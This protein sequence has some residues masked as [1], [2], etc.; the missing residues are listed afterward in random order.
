MLQAKEARYIPPSSE[1]HSGGWLL[2]STI[3]EELTANPND[4][5]LEMISPGQYFLRTPEID[6][7]HITRLRNW[8]I[9]TPTWKLLYELYHLDT[10]KLVNVAVLFHMRLTRPIL[11]MVLVLLGLSV[12]L[13]DQNRNVFISAGMCLGLCA[14]FFASCFTCQCLG[15]YEYLS[16]ATGRL[17]AG[18]GVRPAVAGHV[19]RHSYLTKPP[20]TP[21]FVLHTKTSVCRPG[22][23]AEFRPWRSNAVANTKM[24]KMMIVLGAA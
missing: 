18:A 8:Q 23:I 11:G 1:R 17:G 10:N 3:P 19:R 20:L 12:I 22:E 2:T 16:P 21:R 14:L 15:N 9:Y 24:T 6:F 5:I 7:E 4:D 13:R